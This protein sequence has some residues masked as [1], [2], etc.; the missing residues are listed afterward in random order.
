M[1]VSS[2]LQSAAWLTLFMIGRTTPIVFYLSEYKKKI[3]LDKN[4]E[5]FDLKDIEKIMDRL[6]YYKD[7][8]VIPLFE[9]RDLDVYVRWE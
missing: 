1:D 3:K 5:P 2:Y 7:D 8:D 9:K 4:G 6:V